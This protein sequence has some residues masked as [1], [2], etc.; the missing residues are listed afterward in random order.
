MLNAF[1]HH[2]EYDRADQ[3]LPG[4]IAR[5]STPFG[6]TAS[7]TIPYN[8]GDASLLKC[9]TPFG[10]TASTTI[11]A[12]SQAGLGEECSTPFGITA[13]TT[14]ARRRAWRSS[15]CA[16]RLSASRRVRPYGSEADTT[17]VL[18]CSTPFGITASTT[19][20]E[21][22]ILAEDLDVLNAFRHH[23]EYDARA[24]ADIDDG[25]IACSTPFGITASTTTPRAEKSARW[26]WCSTPFGITASTT[27]DPLSGFSIDLRCSTPF[28]IT[29]ST[30]PLTR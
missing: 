14:A 29:A 10:I 22:E 1:R 26:D 7:T 16:Q 21:A 15:V 12:S 11:D 6:I 9:S 20:Q 30:T 2:G 3:T 27:P 17:K 23:G 25:L 24:S 8:A 13:S 28:G 19:V 4:P 5:C 18:L